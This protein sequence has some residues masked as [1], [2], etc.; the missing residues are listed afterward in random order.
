[1]HF[2]F[3][4]SLN[5][6]SQ[7]YTHAYAE[8]YTKNR[9]LIGSLTDKHITI[10]APSN[11]VESYEIAASSSNIQTKADCGVT[12]TTTISS[13]HCTSNAFKEST[14]MCRRSSDSDISSTPKGK[15]HII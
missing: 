1:M 4:R 3:R 15:L 9:G 7:N 12:S 13:N 11:I 10:S 5:E 8:T 14:D 2:V 6:C